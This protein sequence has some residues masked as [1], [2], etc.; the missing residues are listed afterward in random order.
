MKIDDRE[1]PAAV[2]SHWRHVLDAAPQAALAGL[3][4]AHPALQTGFR[5]GKV[6]LTQLRT[7]AKAL[8]DT[9]S[10]LPEALRA[11]LVHNSLQRELLCA[12]SQEA[13]EQHAAT[14]ADA[15][16]RAAFFGAM[17]LDDRAEVRALGFLHLATWDGEGADDPTV[18]RARSTLVEEMGPFLRCLAPLFSGLETSAAGSVGAGQARGA[19]AAAD[20]FA[21]STAVGTPARHEPP[22]GRIQAPAPSRPPRSADERALVL[23]LRA[24]RQEARRAQRACEEADRERSRLRT[25]VETAD[26]QLAEARAALSRLKD[27]LAVVQACIEDRVREGVQAQVEQRLRPWLAPAEQLQRDVQA[28]CAGPL[29]DGVEALLRRQA[30][31]DHREGLRT[32]LVAELHRTHALLAEV[33][34][35]RLD[36]LNPLPQLPEAAQRLQAH[37][38]ALQDRLDQAARAAV[39][40]RDVSPAVPR[41]PAACA[42]AD[43]AAA[44]LRRLQQ[45]IAA[46]P[47]LDA[48]AALRQQ[49]QA[50]ERLALLTPEQSATVHALLHEAISRLYDRSALAIGLDQAPLPDARDFP[51]QALQAALARRLP[52]TLLVDGHNVLYLLPAL[53][54]PYHDAQGQPTGRARQALAERLQAL[55]ARHP[56]LHVDLWFDGP[57]HDTRS[58]SEQVRVH[59]SG[60][61]GTDRADGAIVAQLRHLGDSLS[62]V[63]RPRA[64]ARPP[65]TDAP[66][67]RVTVVSADSEVRSQVSAL[68]AAVMTPSELALCF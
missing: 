62:A 3:A 5:P 58:L 31:I 16:G 45:K 56:S 48:L 14:W 60:G 46:T 42:E 52:C 21:L 18:S 37:A 33:E 24:Q 36:T 32:S 57:A 17:L 49:L 68:G 43:A 64:G 41:P 28:L 34:R 66:S 59:F 53:F 15:F 20:I 63:D 22:A 51:L 13:I 6:P 2:L 67:R 30:E 27:D 38:A 4:L 23:Q 19:S 40:V 29:L 7:R 61:I 55:A 44:P 65:A 39:A 11:L 35:A 12:L 10:G 1:I 25:R 54:R 47:T 50:A 9:A 8:I 26:A